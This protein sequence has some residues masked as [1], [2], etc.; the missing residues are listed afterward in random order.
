MSDP[1]ETMQ[2]LAMA[3]AHNE[4]VP[5]FYFNG[6]INAL[7]NGDV[8]TVLTR[9]GQP[10]AVLNSSFTVAKTLSTKISEI[11][12]D[13]ET[14]TQAPILDADNVDSLIQRKDQ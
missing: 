1:Q 7:S 2:T 12:Q 5:K 8:V 3:A 11:I 10:V 6:F 14:K 9:N 13:L 4:S